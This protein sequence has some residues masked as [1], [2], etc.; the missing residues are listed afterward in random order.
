MS[1]TVAPQSEQEVT[2]RAGFWIRFLALLIDLVIFA[3]WASLF[4]RYYARGVP[5]VEFYRRISLETLLLFGVFWFYFVVTTR[6]FGGTLGKKALRLE[7]LTLRGRRLEWMD[8]FFREVV[9]RIL[10]GATFMIGYAWSAFDRRKQGWH[11]KIADTQVV[12]HLRAVDLLPQTPPVEKERGDRESERMASLYDSKT[13]LIVVDVQNDFASPEGSLYVEGGEQVVP[14]IDQ[15]IE[16]AK[17]AGTPVFYTQD[18]HPE[19]TPHFEKDGGVWP[20][21]CVQSTWGA[22]FH[23]HLRVEGD[24]IQKGTAGEDGYS[25]FTVRDPVSGTET[26]TGL[27]PRLRARGIERLVV[28]GLA[29]DYCVKETVLDGLRAHF[30]VTV[31]K[32]AVRA[33]DLQAGDGDHAL[34]EMERA[35]SRLL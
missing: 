33:V 2:V 11:D 25:G 24:V 6:F 30:E 29:T 12:R 31:V 14:L 20:V 8:A 1:A 9:G 18:W 13:A 21:H 35:G 26:P 5:D 15:H 10:V 22:R 17:R 7:V 4:N 28:V 34:E 23:P 3:L 32:D 19:D 27:E 16:A